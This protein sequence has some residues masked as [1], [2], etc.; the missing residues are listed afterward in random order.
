[1]NPTFNLRFSW[2]AALW[3]GA[4][5]LAQEDP[6]LRT[7]RGQTMG[8]TYMVKLF[9]APEFAEPIE[10]QIDAELR[11]VNGEMSTY[12]ESSELS[13]FNASESTDWFSV[14]DSVVEV[15]DAALDLSRKTNGAFDVTVGPLVD[16][17][18]FG[19]ASPDGSAVVPDDATLTRAAA[20][21]GYQK[22][23]VRMNPP[24]LRKSVPQVQ[25][26]LSAIA[27][28]HGVDRV[29]ERLKRSGAKNAF[30]EIGGEVR[31]IGSKAGQ[32]WRVGIQMPDAASDVVMI[33]HAM[34]PGQESSMATSG[35]YRN[36]FEREGVRYSHTI[37]P[38]TRRPVTHNLASVTVVAETCMEADAWATAI[39]VLGPEQGMAAAEQY[40]IDA[41][42]V[43]RTSSG[44]AIDAAGSLSQYVSAEPTAEAETSGSGFLPVLLLTTF[45]LSVILIA[46]A[47]GVIFGR[48]SISGSCGG[49]A[50]ERNED[51]SVSCSLCSNP[52]DA[53][54][55]LRERIRRSVPVDSAAEAND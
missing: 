42:L 53:C 3:L 15:V 4:T 9:D 19:A 11:Q 50:N 17:W 32:P 16:A 23:E 18:N 48:R 13:R 8:T 51:G 20:S 14:S 1:M 34:N 43:S 5:A 24:A 49:L 39:N 26:D 27:K 38:R 31:T 2:I 36:H 33:A 22:V 12:L 55:S 35:D 25:I 30:V 46:M 41:L 45:A 52:D 7:I 37:N 44:Y 10:I 54:R 47:V 21:V 28:G 29:V 40:E 6:R